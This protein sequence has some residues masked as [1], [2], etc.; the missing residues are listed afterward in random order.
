MMVTDIVEESHGKFAVWGVT[1]QGSSV[2][3]RVPDFQPYF[4]IAAPCRLVSTASPWSH[5]AV[6][7]HL[8]WGQ[9]W[10]PAN[11]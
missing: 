5:H 1:L 3:V 6:H 7:V 8:V 10:L 9:C 11:A 2:L 4:Y